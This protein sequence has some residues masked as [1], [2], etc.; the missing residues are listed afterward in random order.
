MPRPAQFV[1][2]GMAREAH[3]GRRRRA[4]YVDA[5]LM[6]S[7]RSRRRP[8]RR[9]EREL[10]EP[11]GLRPPA[12]A[13]RGLIGRLGSSEQRFDA[14]GGEDR[15]DVLDVVGVVMEEVPDRET[16]ELNGGLVA[17][18]SVELVRPQSARD[19]GQ[20]T[21]A[22]AFA[23]DDARTMR[24]RHHAMEHELEDRARRPRVL[25]RDSD[26]RSEEHTSE[27]QSQSNLVCRL[28]L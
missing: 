11:R 17:S 19:V 8:P 6:Q 14:T 26:Q 4:L 9:E 18:R 16:F 25:T 12:R 10:E 13:E 23:V 22:V 27:L 5:R 2:G 20:N 21:G 3:D 28:L 1:D 24:E 7:T 15:D